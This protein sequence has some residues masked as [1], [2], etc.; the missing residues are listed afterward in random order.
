M[1]FEQH[2]PQEMK[3][4]RKA[5]ATPAREKMMDAGV[6]VKVCHVTE[7]SHQGQLRRWT[8]DPSQAI[9]ERKEAK[10]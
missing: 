10:P 5:F 6:R 4:R 2:K 3:C 9:R 1:G 7:M 8:R